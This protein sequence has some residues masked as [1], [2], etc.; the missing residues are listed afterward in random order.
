MSL[1]HDA[2]KKAEKTGSAAQGGQGVFLDSERSTGSS[3]KRI[4][5]LS[6][7]ASL[8]LLFVTYQKFVKKPAAPGGPSRAAPVVQ[9]DTRDGGK[10]LEEAQKL[11]Q[12]GRYEDARGS[13]EKAV[14]TALPDT[15]KAEAYNNLGFVLKKLGRTEEAFQR[16]QKALALDPQCAECRN[17]LGVLYLSNRDF[18]EAETHF[19]EALKARPDYAEPHLH[20][21]L[22]LEARGDYAGAKKRYLEYTKLARGVSADFLVKIQER[23]AALEAM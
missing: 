13:L 14:F 1:L 6:A 12:Q 15:R 17:N 21:A 16:Y 7:V 10:L 8:L 4:F 11:I 9:S 23:I 19:Q 5:V 2:L 18:T 3:N 22:L 20:L